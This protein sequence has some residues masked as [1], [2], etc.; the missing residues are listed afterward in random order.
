MQLNFEAF[1]W[2]SRERMLICDDD[3]NAGATRGVGMREMGLLTEGSHVTVESDVGGE[4]ALT[5]NKSEA[6]RQQCGSG[7]WL[8][9]LRAG[10]GKKAKKGTGR[11]AALTRLS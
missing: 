5:G 4:A 3:E 8:L 7:V 6:K 9:D 10:R 11:K 2:W 1:A